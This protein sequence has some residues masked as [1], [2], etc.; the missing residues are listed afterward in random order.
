MKLALLIFSPFAALM[1]L[2]GI[3]NPR[4]AVIFFL[5]LVLKG[6][7]AIGA[8]LITI[9]LGLGVLAIPFAILGT[10]GLE[11]GRTG[12]AV[13][14]CAA[15]IFSIWNIKRIRKTRTPRAED[16]VF[17]V[18][19][20]I[21]G[22]AFG[23]VCALVGAIIGILLA[24]GIVQG[25]ALAGINFQD[26][27]SS[28]SIVLAAVGAVCGFLSMFKRESNGTSNSSVREGRVT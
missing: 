11:F 1:I 19:L 7:M 28:F 24:L 15:T 16:L 2:M 12:L 4:G 18:F 14:L 22:A 3:L 26:L 9:A 5:H 20:G 6:L 13:F 17:S 25:A 21:L 10:V 27:Q 23:A 8:G